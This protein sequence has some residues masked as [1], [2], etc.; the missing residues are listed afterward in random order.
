LNQQSEN[1]FN[2]KSELMLTRH[3]IAYSSSC[4]KLSVYLQLFRR[5]SFLK[6]AL[7]Q[8]IAKINKT[9]YFG[10]SGSFIVINVD[11]TKKL[12]TSACCNRQHAT[13]DLQPFSRKTGQQR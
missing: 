5:N 7:Q 12:V 3:A 2:K 9:P 13:G 8:K 6:C 10:S 11:M 4:C 1:N